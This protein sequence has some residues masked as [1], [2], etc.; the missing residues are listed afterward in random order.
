MTVFFN[1]QEIA[2]IY[3]NNTKIDSAYY[4]STLVYTANPY[5]PDYTLCNNTGE[6]TFSQIL[7]KG[8]Y[9]LT[10]IGGG[11]NGTQWAFNGYIWG[12]GGGSGSGFIGEFFNPIK[13]QV[14][15]YA[16]ANANTSYMNFQET[17]MITC[18]QGT[19]AGFNAVGK[20]GTISVNQNLQHNAQ[21]LNG[22]DGSSGLGSGS[23]GKTISPVNNWGAGGSS[24]GTAGGIILI[25]KRTKF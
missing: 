22:N 2:D 6:Y 10:L 14:T 11:G 21:L 16:G 13:Q 25:Y 24:S 1:S 20:G 15:I 8:V 17:R 12:A 18:N 9:H 3:L 4:G 23:G 5:D 7:P 19:N